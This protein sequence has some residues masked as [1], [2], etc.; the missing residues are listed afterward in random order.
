M[1]VLY[2][3]VFQ[4]GHEVMPYGT[5]STTTSERLSPDGGSKI[6]ENVLQPFL[7]PDAATVQWN[8]SA[9]GVYIALLGGLQV[10]TCIWFAMI[11]RVVARVLRG[12]GAD[13]TRSDD[14][15]EEDDD[16]D[17][18]PARPTLSQRGSYIEIAAEAEDLYLT[19]Q[20]AGSGRIG[21]TRKKSRGISSG[22]SLGDHKDILNRIGCLSDEQL[23][24]EA[25]RRQESSSPAPSASVQAPSGNAPATTKR[26]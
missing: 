20:R 1:A 12:E 11:C 18:Q 2:S 17:K 6:F 5:Y 22:L 26:T 14:E 16:S 23:A 10:L 13:D 8:A 4:L 19:A 25:E 21:V 9:R 3:I 15:G 7:N 24:R